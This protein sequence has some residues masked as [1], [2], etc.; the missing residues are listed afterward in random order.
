MPLPTMNALPESLRNLFSS[1]TTRSGSDYSPYLIKVDVPLDSLI[2]QAIARDNPDPLG[3]PLTTPPSSPTASRPPSPAPSPAPPALDPDIP[4]SPPFQIETPTNDDPPNAE[5]MPSSQSDRKP[6]RKRRPKSDKKHSHETRAKKRK[7]QWAT[8]CS[9]EHALQEHHPHPRIFE[10]AAPTSNFDPVNLKTSSASTG[11]VGVNAPLPEI[12]QYC[13]EDLVHNGDDSFTL[14]KS[15]PGV[16]RYIPCCDTGKIMAIV[17]PGPHKDPTWAVT[18]KEA[19]DLLR[20]L[21]PQCRFRP[22][23]YSKTRTRGDVSA[24]HFGISMGNGQQ[25]PMV[26]SDLGIGNRKLLPVIL[27]IFLTWAPQLFFY[28]VQIMA[29]LLGSDNQLFRPFSNSPFAAFTVN[30]GPK[31]VCLPHRDSKNLAFGWCGICALGTY[32]HVKGGHL[33]LWD[34]K[35]MIEFPPGTIIFIPS[36]VCC[37][38]NTAIQDEEERFSFTT[39]S[40]GGLFRWVEHGFQLED[41]FMKTEEAVKQAKGKHENWFRGIN[42]FSSIEEL[43]AQF[44]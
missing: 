30:F 17:V 25:K 44:A 11:Y 27:A 6:K 43:Q 2:F 3:S 26:L 40:A 35:L 28:Y 19:A 10:F 24:L 23:D 42:L 31:T 36:A 14:L 5:P 38:F 41:A 8:L 16:T 20:Q 12:Q 29:L 15:E 1:R 34:L 7:L 9:D 21:R 37:H 18:C 33:V 13:L 22:P 32:D 4:P 39:Y